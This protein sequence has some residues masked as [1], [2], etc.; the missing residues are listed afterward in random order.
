MPGPPR[1]RTPTLVAH[2]LSAGKL[3]IPTVTERSET[4]LRFV[5]KLA[6]RNPEVVYGDG[7]ERTRDS[8]VIR[9]FCRK[10]AAEGMV[11]LRNK[12]ALL[13][14]KTVRNGSL[15]VAVIG[16]NAKGYVISGGGSAALKAS[17]VATPYDGIIEAK[18][19][20]VDISYHV[21][22]YGKCRRT[23]FTPTILNLFISTQV[24]A[25]ARELPADT[26]WRVW[27]AMHFPQPQTWHFGSL[28][29]G[30]RYIRPWRHACQA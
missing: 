1:W 26:V 10:L 17:Y 7:E 28:T 21:G 20:G 8:P 12:D 19:D 22:C 15:K 5:Q 27:L 30:Y 3:S 13:P 25:Y 14:L 16:P 23:P 24:P 29:G 6:K 11:L 9:K 18:P 4:L 2:S